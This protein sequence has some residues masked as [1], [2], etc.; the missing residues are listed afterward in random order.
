MTFSDLEEK[1]LMALYQEQAD[2]GQSEVIFFHD[3]AEKYE[4]ERK[5]GWLLS[6]QK[7]L[8][9]QGLIVGPGS[10]QNDEMAGGKITGAGMRKI[11]EKYGDKDGVGQILAP[12]AKESAFIEAEDGSPMSKEDGAYILAESAT[13]NSSNIARVISSADWTGISIRLQ[14][15]PAVVSMIAS[16]IGEIDNLVERT[17]LTNTERQKAKAITDSLRLLV[18]SPEPEWKAIATLLTSPTLTAILNVATIVQLVLGIFGLA[19]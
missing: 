12:L 11:E 5:P 6:A 4:L 3:L 16:H 9:S 1:L 17:G 18:A 10:S 19:S 14:S 15:D 8:I 2:G 7:D 13:E